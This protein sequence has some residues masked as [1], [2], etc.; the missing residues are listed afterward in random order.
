[1]K[2]RIE[3]KSRINEEKAMQKEKIANTEKPVAQ[4]DAENALVTV[5]GDGVD[6]KGRSRKQS[7]IAL[8]RLQQSDIENARNDSSSHSSEDSGDEQSNANTDLAYS[9]TNSPTPTSAPISPGFASDPFATPEEAPQT[10]ASR[11]WASRQRSE[12][13]QTTKYQH[14]EH[15]F[16]TQPG[17]AKASIE[18]LHAS[19]N[20]TIDGQG[21]IH[22]SQ[23][24]QL[25]GRQSPDVVIF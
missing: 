8:A 21:V 12:N 23:L 24:H 1:M 13:G 16:S 10:P 14:Y 9:M 18:G 17:A 4:R 20:V 25:T 22:A 19:N 15:V 3:D 7:A 2:R 11:G 6:I 5:E